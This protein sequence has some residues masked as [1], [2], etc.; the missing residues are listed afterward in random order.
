[1]RRLLISAVTMTVAALLLAPAVFAAPD[2][3][4]TQRLRNGVTTNG[5]LNHMRALQRVANANDGNRAASTTGY[6]AS[7][8]LC[9]AASGLG[10][11]TRRNASRSNTPIGCRTA[12]ALL[13]RAGSTAYLEGTDLAANDY[14]V[15]FYS[16]SGNVAAPVVTTGTAELPPSGGPGTGTDGC[17]AVRLDGRGPGRQD[18]PRSAGWLRLRG[19]DRAGQ[20]LGAAAVVIFNDGGE[21]V[22]EPFQFAAEP[23]EHDSGC[24]ARAM[25]PV[26]LSTPRRRLVPSASRSTSPL[27]PS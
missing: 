10:P 3:V 4:N 24:H 2:D 18:R 9:R 23:F 11:A 22:T 6:D 12:P 27:R 17:E 15:A 14:F 8:G 21:D 19:Q 20:S 16:G 26:K 1:M 25:T 13:Q 7:A 5:I